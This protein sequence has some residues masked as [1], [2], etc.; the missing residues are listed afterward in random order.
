MI[1]WSTYIMAKCPLT[2]EL[3]KFSPEIYIEAPTKQLALEWAQNNGLGY[4]HIGDQIVCTI[5]S[6][7]ERIDFDTYLN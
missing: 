7:G 4:L 1:T 3:L 2:G 5:D 6:Q